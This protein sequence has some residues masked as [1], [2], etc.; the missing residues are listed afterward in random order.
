M[1]KILIATITASIGMAGSAMQVN[2]GLLSAKGEIIA[3]LAGELFP[4]KAEGHLSGAGTLVIYSRK[5]SN[6]TCR[7]QFTSSAERGGLG[8]LVCGDGASATFQFQRLSVLRGYGSGKFSRGEMSFAYGLGADDVGP[9]LKL[10][11]G[12]RLA[13]KGKEVKLADL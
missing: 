4:G 3:I 10:P 8:Q 12:K 5:D 6:L 9:Y 2:A 13:Y 11:Q 7:G 1:R